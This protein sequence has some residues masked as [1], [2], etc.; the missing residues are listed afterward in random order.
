MLLHICAYERHLGL[1][2][3]VSGA[4][5]G[6][7]PG[8][9]LDGCLGK[10]VGLWPSQR[11]GCWLGSWLVCRLGWWL[12]CLCKP[13]ISLFLTANNPVRC[14]EDPLNNV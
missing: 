2:I 13:K 6:C 14:S 5:I 1:L 12:G 11:L 4:R 3:I 7:L 10:W 9:W 8:R